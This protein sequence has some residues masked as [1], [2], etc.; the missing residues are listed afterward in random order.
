LAP[1]LVLAQDAEHALATLQSLGVD[2]ELS[3]RAQEVPAA[4]VDEGEVGEAGENGG[5]EDAGA[6]ASALEHV[7]ASRPLFARGGVEQG[8]HSMADSDSPVVDGMASSHDPSI[9]EPL[10]HAMPDSDSPLPRG[11]GPS[12]QGGQG[13]AQLSV[14]G[15]GG[16]GT[17]AGARGGGTEVGVADQSISGQIA[18]TYCICMHVSSYIYVYV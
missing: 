18:H 9:Y 10:V 1:W 8:V 5:A 15:E 13:Y 16:G 14:V 17:T 11:G 6:G 7:P 3:L 12:S 2:G 4:I